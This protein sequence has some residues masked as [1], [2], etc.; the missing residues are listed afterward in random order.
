MAKRTKP[1]HANSLAALKAHEIKPGE[2]RNPQGVNRK[3]PWS[4]RWAAKGEQLLSAT[5]NGE[6]VRLQFKLGPDATWADAIV[7]RIAVDAVQG[8][9]GPAQSMIDRVEGCAPR[10]MEISTPAGKHLRITVKYDRK[11]LR[12]T[13]EDEL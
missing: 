6:K 11:T 12:P 3:Q 8:D 10:R 7:E 4:E 9:H 2:V 5:E 13:T 1:A